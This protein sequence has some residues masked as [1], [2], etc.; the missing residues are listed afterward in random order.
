MAHSPEGKRL[1][2]QRPKT[3]L[4]PHISSN[5]DRGRK[6]LHQGT[7]LEHRYDEIK[8]TRA[9]VADGEDENSKIKLNYRFYKAGKY[10]QQIPSYQLSKP[11]S[12]WM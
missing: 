11:T 10:T 12:P 2:H 4:W 6:A 1:L 9:Q 3:Y 7:S 8:D 5:P